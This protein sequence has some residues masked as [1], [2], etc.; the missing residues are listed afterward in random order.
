MIG[1]R[2]FRN[3]LRRGKP[4]SP[5][6]RGAAEEQGASSRENTALQTHANRPNMVTPWGRQDWTATPGTDPATGL[7]INSWES[8]ITLSGPQQE[9]L[10]AQM[11]IQTGRSNAAN[12]LLGQATEAFDTPFDWGGLTE[13]QGLDDVGYDPVG[14]RDRAEQ[15][16]FQRQMNLQEPKL[17]Q[18]EDARRARMEAMGI[19][20]EGGSQAFERAQAGMDANRGQIRENAA[21]NAISGGGQEA[22]RELGLATGA[23][24]FNNQQ[25]AA[26]IAEEAQRRGMS[27]N[28]LNALLTGQQVQLPE[29]S[30]GQ[31]GSTAGKADTTNYLGA[32]QLQGQ[33]DADTAF[34]WGAAMGA[35]TQAAMSFSDRR[36]K[37][38]IVSLGGGLHEYRL[39]GSNKRE[40]GV[41]ADELLE[42]HPERVYTHSSGYLMV[43]YGD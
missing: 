27:L 28:E 3:D 14:A 15:A 4:D 23:A 11:E 19:P 21:L 34:D 8:N 30:Q 22:G 12:Q 1:R 9:A 17:T 36:L 38:D 6:Y 10:D 2:Q 20:L 39:L 40:I 24:G 41:M 18:Q 31:P 13:R 32:A 16:L 37:R 29:V 7:P 33:F 25:R 43:R 5:D 42:T 26:E 35:G